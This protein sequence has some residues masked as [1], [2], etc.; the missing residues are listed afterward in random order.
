M[1]E[2]ANPSPGEKSF[3][4][5]A[6][7]P[8]LGGG[9]KPGRLTIADCKARFEC[10]AGSVEWPLDQVQL[11]LGGHND[12]RLFLTRAANPKAAISTGDLSLL[13]HPAFQHSRLREQIARTRR[14]TVSKV[15]HIRCNG[16]QHRR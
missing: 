3:S 16:P 11:N 15:F 10:E 13:E 2:S 12:A 5:L 7:L 8:E 4:A 6:S 9:M 14:H 1:N